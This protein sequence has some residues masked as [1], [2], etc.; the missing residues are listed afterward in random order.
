MNTIITIGRQ[1]GSGGREIGEKLASYFSVGFYDRELLTRAASESGFCRELLENHDERP[2]GSFLFNLFMDT[3]SFGH[4]ASH[5]VEIPLGQKVFLAQFDT[6]RKIA[7]EG[8]CVI[9][10]R[11]ADYALHGAA[12]TLN[13]FITAS[14]S[15]RIERVMERHSVNRQKAA[16]M[17]QKT[18]KDRAS[19]YNY[20]TSGKWGHAGTYDLCVNSS[21]LGIDGTVRQLASFIEEY[22][23]N[24]H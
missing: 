4:N 19:Y 5:F 23:N 22:E 17:I 9:V 21:M 10:G 15:A 7:S 1:Y 6:I 20:Y 2:T 13:I 11:C 24:E 3:C 14:E 18:D 12:R 8:P 16:E